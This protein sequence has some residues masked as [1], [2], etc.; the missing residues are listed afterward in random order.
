MAKVI[1]HRAEAGQRLDRFLRKLLQGMPTSHIF[2]L[3]RTRKVRVNGKQGR[4]EQVLEPGDEILVHMVEERF[5]EDTKR[6]PCSATQIDFRVVFEDNFLLVVAKPPFL[7]V[8]SGA[9]HRSNSLI[10]QIHG[11]LEIDDDAPTTFRPSLAHRLDKDTSGLVLVGKSVEVLQ[12]LTR[13]FQDGEVKK[14]YLALAKGIPEPRSGTWSYKVERRDVPGSARAT[15]PTRGRKDAQG[16]TSYQVA[17][18]RSLHL[19]GGNDQP[20]SLLLLTPHTGRTHQL[21][22]HLFQAHHPI[23]GDPRYGDPDLNR[24]FRTRYQLER[25]FL[26]A[27]Q[28]QLAHP[29]S[30]KT[31]RLV[32]PFPADLLPIVQSLRLEIPKV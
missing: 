11:Y 15:A 32:D 9:G 16:K 6:R 5:H 10:D 25:Q 28:L 4:A 22:S 24:L 13:M 20:M 26:H 14:T 8:H 30:G 12:R 23:A 3:L 29:V 19:P 7:P 17:M 1:V 21:R 18:T 31:L 27:F 2:K